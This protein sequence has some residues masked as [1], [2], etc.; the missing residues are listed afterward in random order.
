MPEQQQ[1]YPKDRRPHPVR[2]VLKATMFSLQG[3]RWA[4]KY[5]QAI[6]QEMIVFIVLIPLALWLDVS[7]LER[8]LLLGSWAMVI[9]VELLNS[10]VEATVDRIGIEHHKLSG[11]AKD[12]GSAAVFC[13]ILLS[14]ATWTVILS[15]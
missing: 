5:E 12:I 13:A 7:P 4:W 1:S 3:L 15:A 11:R 10:A 14:F 2:R 8:L 6:R 9:I